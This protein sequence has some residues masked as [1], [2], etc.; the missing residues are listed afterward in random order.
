MSEK[1]CILFHRNS[2]NLE[3]TEE[4]CELMYVGDNG[5]RHNSTVSPQKHAEGP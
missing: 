3:M 1:G 4:K 5:R 2:G